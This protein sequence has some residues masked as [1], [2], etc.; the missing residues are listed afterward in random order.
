MCWAMCCASSACFDGSRSSSAHSRCGLARVT[1]VYWSASAA[2]GAVG[3]WYGG[4]GSASG[5]YYYGDWYDPGDGYD[6]ATNSG[7]ITTD[8][9]GDDGSGWD[10]PDDGSGDSSSDPGGDPS[11]DTGDSSGD[12]SDSS[13]DSVT[14]LHLYSATSSPAPS[15][16][17][18][19]GCFSC[20]MGCRTDA[21]TPTGRQAIGA[22]D[23]GYDDACTSAVRTLA[24]WAHDA[25][26]EK[27]VSCQRIAT[28]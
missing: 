1:N 26:R 2:A 6:P 23:I 8:P 24:Q 16:G 12:G 22:S 3:A 21:A 10:Q 25:R 20:T 15:P 18:A 17:V 7:G 11:A 19:D 28:P 9:N 5:N 4:A 27:I 14:R 13:G